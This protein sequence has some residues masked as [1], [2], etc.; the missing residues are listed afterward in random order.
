[1]YKNEMKLMESESVPLYQFLKM[2][3]V[4]LDRR[5]LP[6]LSR[7][8]RVLYEQLSI[9]EIEALGTDN[10]SLKGSQG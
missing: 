4:N 6:L 5:L 1:M 7:L 8:E 10:D 2:H 3:E 9:E